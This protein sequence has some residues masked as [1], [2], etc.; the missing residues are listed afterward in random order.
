MA[1]I[2]RTSKGHLKEYLESINER[3]VVW[4]I[5]KSKFMESDKISELVYRGNSKNPLYVQSTGSNK[6]AAKAVKTM[7]GD[8]RIPDMLKE[9]DKLSRIF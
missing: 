2:R 8:F 1:R 4:G 3:K 7:P 9:V 5:A 6:I